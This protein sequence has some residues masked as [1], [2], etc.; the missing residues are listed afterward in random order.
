MRNED[1]LLWATL[2]AYIVHTTHPVA[3]VL[4][5]GTIPATETPHCAMW[6][7]LSHRNRDILPCVTPTA[8][9]SHMISITEK[10][11]N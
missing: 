8:T 9:E 10:G 1:S 6:H 7:I 5:R 2:P 3:C 4:P 11:N